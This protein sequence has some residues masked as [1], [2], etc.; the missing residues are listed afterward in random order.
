MA[1]AEQFVLLSLGL[2]VIGIRIFERWRQ[3]GGP[4]GW[5]FD[6]YL[7]PLVGVSVPLFCQLLVSSRLSVTLHASAGV[8]PTQLTLRPPQHVSDVALVADGYQSHHRSSSLSKPS[9]PSRWST[10]VMG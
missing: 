4:K 10:Y 6:D 2:I 3:V 9:Q 1:L 7:M 5:S 8:T